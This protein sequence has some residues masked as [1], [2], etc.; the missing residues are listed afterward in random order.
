MSLKS[1]YILKNRGCLKIVKL[2]R[3]LEENYSIINSVNYIF[4]NL[5]LFFKIDYE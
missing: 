2:S 4:Q 1:N 3:C 5:I